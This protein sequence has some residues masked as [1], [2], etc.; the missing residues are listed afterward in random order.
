MVFKCSSVWPFQLW[1][2]TIKLDDEQVTIT[3]RGFLTRTVIPIKLSD[4]LNVIVYEAPF[5]CTVE[6]VYKYVTAEHEKI[7]YIWNKDGRQLQHYCMAI[8]ERNKHT[9]QSGG[10]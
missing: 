7:A 9:D 1:P 8:I 6:V 2:D 3:K 10:Q 4:L 5:F